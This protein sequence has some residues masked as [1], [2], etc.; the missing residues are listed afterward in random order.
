MLSIIITLLGVMNLVRALP[1]GEKVDSL[2]DFATFDKY[3]V[4]SG[5]IPLGNTT[6]T[7]HYVLVQS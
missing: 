3:G 5:Y 1:A 6:K 7:I 4:Y 2:P